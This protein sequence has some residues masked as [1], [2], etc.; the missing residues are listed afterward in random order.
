MADKLNA[1]LNT[2]AR[3]NF[4]IKLCRWLNKHNNKAKIF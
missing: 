3:F 1:K 4:N 2:R